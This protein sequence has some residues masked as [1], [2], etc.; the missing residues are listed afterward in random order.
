MA[1]VLV[2][3][4]VSLSRISNRRI[5]SCTLSRF[6]AVHGLHARESMVAMLSSIG[7]KRTIP[8]NRVNSA[9]STTRCRVTSSRDDPESVGAVLIPARSPRIPP[10]LDPL[11]PQ[12]YL[13]YEKPHPPTVGLCV[14]P[15]CVLRGRAVS[16]V[17]GTPVRRA[18]T[19]TDITL[20]TQ[21]A[22]HQTKLQPKCR[23]IRRHGTG[24]LFTNTRNQMDHRVST[25]T[26]DLY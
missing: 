5:T 12:V 22:S 8:R 1:A 21:G 2:V 3:I 10:P 7:S 6:L 15:Y 23:R 16:Y 17:R 19:D 26:K 9:R 4:K 14:G 25:L 13:T 18:F 20:A 24:Q 11:R